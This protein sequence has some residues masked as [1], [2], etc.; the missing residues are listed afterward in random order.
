VPLCRRL[1]TRRLPD[2][3]SKSV[4]GLSS[5][6]PR[7]ARRRRSGAPELSARRRA[8]RAPGCSRERRVG[9]GRSPLGG[10]RLTSAP[11]GARAL[12]ESAT[13]EI[14]AMQPE[15]CGRAIAT[16]RA[17]DRL[18]LGQA[19]A[20]R[21]GFAPARAGRRSAPPTAG[22]RARP[23]RPESRWGQD[24]RRCD[25]PPDLGQ[26][27]LGLPSASASSRPVS[28]PRS[29]TFARSARS[30][31]PPPPTSRACG[32]RPRSAPPS[33]VDA[34]RLR[35][36][37]ILEPQRAARQLARGVAA[38]C[39]SLAREL[40]DEPIEAGDAPPFAAISRPPRHGAASRRD[41]SGGCRRRPRSRPAPGR[42]R[43]QRPA[44]G[45]R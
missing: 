28:T 35:S 33:R 25:A 22:C 14:D 23:S 43:R 44:A 8:R 13:R 6:P 16:G 26:R 2:A 17:P 20:K 10:A 27:Q 12:R 36:G 7:A 42:A 24:P 39:A 31:P 3:D 32:I 45:R 9:I 5:S 40:L 37:A 34:L 11:A 30:M 29:S 18:R 4:L 19:L 38:R 15:G 21:N 1:Y 41:S